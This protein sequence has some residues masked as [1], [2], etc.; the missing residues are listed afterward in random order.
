LVNLVEDWEILEDYVGE[1]LGFYQILAVDGS[2]EIRVMTGRLGYRK[3]FKDGNDKL[4]NQILD[5]CKKQRF[6]QISEHLR[7]EDFFK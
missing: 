5:F 1:K 2:F 4:L 3:E 7:D 6:I